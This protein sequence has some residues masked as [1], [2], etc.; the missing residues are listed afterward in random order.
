MDFTGFC[1]KLLQRTSPALGI[2]H[3]RRLT[4]RLLGPESQVPAETWR[5]PGA[6]SPGQLVCSPG[7][8]GS[9]EWAGGT[10]KI[11][12]DPAPPPVP[13]HPWRKFGD[14]QSKFG[15][16]AVITRACFI[17]APQGDKQK[18]K[19]R[20]PWGRRQERNLLRAHQGLRGLCPVCPTHPEQ[21]LR[22]TAK[23]AQ[24]HHPPCLLSPLVTPLLPS[25]ALTSAELRGK[26]PGC[27]TH[28]LR[29][30]TALNLFNSCKTR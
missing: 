17:Q 13:A 19:K 1:Q 22:G 26:G 3:A 25:C 27:V 24:N 23:G 29:D 20:G 28:Q 5:G 7:L 11:L 16:F 15:S 6:S 10:D 14:R 2:Q 18:A 8:C 30:L 12:P 4:P 21:L 9:V